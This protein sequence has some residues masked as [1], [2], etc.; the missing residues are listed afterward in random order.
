MG[1]GC[2]SVGALGG[3]GPARLAAATAGWA[4]SGRAARVVV[5]DVTAGSSAT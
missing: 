3:P 5:V 2:T 1:V 4:T